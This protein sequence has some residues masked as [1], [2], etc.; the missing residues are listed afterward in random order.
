M[1]IAITSPGDAAGA[2]TTAFAMA[3]TWPDRV[4]LAECSPAG[5]KIMRGYFRYQAPPAGGLWELALA[6]VHGQA[7]TAEALWDQT[8]ALD[9]A[10]QRLLLPGLS[11]PFSSSELSAGTWDTLA[12]TFADLPVTVLADTGP[13]G[14]E[15]PFAVLRAADLVLL[16][17]R[18]T[19]AQVVAARPR[20]ARLRKALGAGA[21]LGLCLIGDRPYTPRDI[22]AALGEFA[23]TLTFPVDERAA[24]ILSDGGGSDWARRRIEV[25]PLMR[26]ASAAG[27]A[28][29]NFAAGQRRRIFV[30]RRAVREE[31]R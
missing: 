10:R 3:L 25:S 1:L 19:L 26:A 12:A 9:T 21:P 30:P 18:P 27:Q 15:Q 22:R 17:M 11:D 8:I 6:A 31:R 2:T 28:A 14:P 24:E 23:L 7:A 29:A 16:V 5:G 20:L 13:I 4:L